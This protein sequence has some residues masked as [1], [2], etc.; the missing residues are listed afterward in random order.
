MLNFLRKH[1]EIIISGAFFLVLLIVGI[2][3]YRDFGI[4]WDTPVQQQLGELNYRFIFLKDPALL[5]YVNRYY[6]PLFELFLYIM[7]RGLAVREL[8]FMQ[9]L[10][11]FLSF[12]AGTLAFYF[13]SKKIF[14]DWRLGL[15]GCVMLVLSPRIFS[16]SFYNTK[17]I[18][19]LAAFILAILTLVWVSEHPTWFRFLIH[20]LASAI[21]VAFRLQGVL[22][23]ALTAAFIGITFFKETSKSNRLRIVWSAGLYLLITLAFVVLFFPVLWT[24]PLGGLVNGLKEMGN[25]PWSGGSVLYRGLLVDATNLPWHYVPVWIVITT[26]L[27]ISVFFVIGIGSQIWSMMRK[28]R[29]LFMTQSSFLLAL[30][31]LLAPVLAVILLHSTL[32]DSWRHMFFIYPAYVLIALYGLNS[33]LHLNVKPS[34]KKHFIAVVWLGLAVGLAFPLSFMIRYHPHEN[35]YFNRLAGSDYETIKEHYEMDYWGL[36]YYQALEYIVTND[37]RPQIKV[38]YDNYPVKAN[39]TILNPEDGMRLKFVGKDVTDADYFITNFRWHPQEYDYPLFYSINV[40][41]ASIITV[42]KLN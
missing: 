20:A 10:L 21:C 4:T 37:P 42:Y 31:W 11:T 35:V 23:L 38:I 41:G 16:D 6:G 30:L 40:E 22:I 33:M 39:A 36:G 24:D 5:N 8:N 2:M 17:D 15:A 19:F 18:P 12:Y 3:I 13:L 14:K 32:Y 1:Q 29:E 34:L 26:P 9:H 25:F 28:P 27:V 7:T